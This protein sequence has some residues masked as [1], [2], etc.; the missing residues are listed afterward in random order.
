MEKGV[1][2]GVK[3]AMPT[4]LGYISIGGSFGIVAASAG[5]STLEVG[6]MSALVYG[7]S[8]QFS[9]VSL[10]LSGINL[11][12]IT[13]TVFLL[14]LRNML[15]SLDATTIFLNTNFKNAIG[16]ASLITDESYGVLLGESLYNDHITVWWMHGNNVTGY[17]V[18][19]SSTVIGTFLG[20]IIQNPRS[21]GL[22]FALV[23]MFIGLLMFQWEAMLSEGMKKLLLISGAIAVSFLLL[24][25]FL[26]GSLTILVVTLIGC[27]VG[28]CYDEFIQ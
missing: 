28:V 19:L 8:A 4:A 10:L 27:S 5:L 2:A 11:F 1:I 9:M 20:N 22:D 6:L 13:L 26:S 14:N 23:A 7:G 12:E 24:S 17:L 16:I 3:D 18:W 21:Y 15:M 25:I